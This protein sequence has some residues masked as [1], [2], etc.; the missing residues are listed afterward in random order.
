[1]KIYSYFNPKG[2]VLG[3][4]IVCG[5]CFEASKLDYLDQIGVKDSKKL[6]PTKRK[7][8]SNL[9]KKKCV[10]YKEIEVSGCHFPCR[11]S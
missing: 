2:P 9:I 3:P 4:M 10:C 5:V 7:T 11:I 8:L 6:N 1:M